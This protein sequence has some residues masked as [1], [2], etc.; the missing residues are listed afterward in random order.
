MGLLSP[1]VHSFFPD[2]LLQNKKEVI[3]S[4]LGAVINDNN[5]K[6]GNLEMPVANKQCITYRFICFLDLINH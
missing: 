4:G 1:Y 2:E 3:I 5:I 6:V